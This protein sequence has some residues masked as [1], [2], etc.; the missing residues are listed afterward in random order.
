MR[1]WIIAIVVIVVIGL[2]AA[3]A[4]AAQQNGTFGMPWMTGG[5]GQMMNDDMMEDAEP[6]EMMQGGGM[7]N[8][9]GHMMDEDYGRMMGERFGPMMYGDD[10]ETHMEDADWEAFHEDMYERMEA[11]H[12]ANGGPQ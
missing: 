9:R 4:T 6:G 3:G 7:M 10:W 8:G 12:E 11:C 2:L 5:H 1:N